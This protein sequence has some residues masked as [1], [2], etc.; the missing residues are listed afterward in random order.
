AALAGAALAAGATPLILYSANARG[1]AFVVAAY[2]IL[3]LIGARVRRDGSHCGA[4]VVFAIVG[5]AG[6]VAIPVM[7]Y[8]LGAV[9]LWLVLV[10]GVERGRRAWPALGALTLS[11]GAALALAFLAYLPIIVAHGLD[12]IVANRFVEPSPWPQFFAQLAPSLPQ[13]ARSWTQPYPL[14]VAMV[15]GA[16]MLAGVVWSTRVSREGV[17]VALAAYVWCAIL[18]LGTHRAP[19]TRNWLWLFP[20]VALAVGTLG[21]MLVSKPRFRALGPY[22]PAFAVVVA[23]AG[24]SW[25]FVTDAVVAMPQSGV[26]AG[27]EQIANALATQTQPGDRVLAAIPADAPLKYYML[28]AGADTALFSTPDSVATREIIVLNAAYGQTVPWAIAAGMVDTTR[29]GPIAPAVH[30][31]DGNVFVAELREHGR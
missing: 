25:G 22:G 30:A 18:L 16:A 6:I 7:L 27:A 20:V 2:L 1:Y 10:L 4:W 8:P 24:V 17:S 19:F 23:V 31:A 13:L 5:A 3:L 21:D 28:R 29:F 12:A 15:L 9:A 14:A 11:L 26:F